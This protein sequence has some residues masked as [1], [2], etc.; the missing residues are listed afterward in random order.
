MRHTNGADRFFVDTNVLLYSVDTAAPYKQVAARHWLDILWM[1]G[2]GRLSWQ[3]L[4]E[5]YV[6]A[7]RKIGTPPRQ[8]RTAVE[9]FALW[10]P[11]DTTLGLAQ[12]AWQWM[13]KAQLTYWDALILAAAEYAGCVWLL[14]EDFSAGPRYGPV[15]VINPFRESPATF[16]LG[17]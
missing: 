15:T 6:N 11:V 12:R 5:F 2:A 4:N 8:A 14:S 13:D 17:R 3:V 16:G 9:T 10:K 7:L 1:N